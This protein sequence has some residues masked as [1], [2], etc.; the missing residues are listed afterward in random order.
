VTLLAFG[1]GSPDFFAALASVTD[2]NGDVGLTFGA[3][4]GAALFVS[5]IVAGTISVIQP[6]SS[7]ER[8]L[9]R[10]LLFF[11]SSSFWLFKII[12]V[13]SISLFDS[14]GRKHR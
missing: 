9:L 5:T 3:L 2:D 8:P 7:S 11:I 4:M 12:W 10:D 6:F 13:G 14:I 1:N